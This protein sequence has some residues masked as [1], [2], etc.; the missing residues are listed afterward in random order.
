VTGLRDAL[1]KFTGERGYIA[2]YDGHALTVICQNPCCGET[3]NAAANYNGMFI[4]R[5]CVHW[6]SPSI[7]NF[8]YDRFSSLTT[9]PPLGRNVVESCG[10]AR[11]SVV[12]V[13]L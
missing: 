3:R 9:T 10:S 6:I 4:R 5:L 8:S 7:N 2:F 12:L 1:A 11:F 13:S